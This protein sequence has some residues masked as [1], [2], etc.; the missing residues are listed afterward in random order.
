MICWHDPSGMLG[1]A[2]STDLAIPKLAAPVGG[3]EFLP[4]L[5]DLYC[6]SVGIIEQGFAPVAALRKPDPLVGDGRA[7]PTGSAQVAP[8]R[9]LAHGAQHFFQA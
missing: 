7:L 8:R 6:I 4:I 9:Q 1:L 5:L 2:F 3:G